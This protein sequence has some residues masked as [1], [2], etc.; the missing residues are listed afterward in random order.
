MDDQKK[1]MK[2]RNECLCDAWKVI[3]L[4]PVTR[5]NKKS[6]TYWKWIKEQFDERKNFGTYATMHMERDKSTMSHIWGNIQAVC[7][8][9]HGNRTTVVNRR[10]SATTIETQVRLKLARNRNILTYTLY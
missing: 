7:N 1:R 6:D 5:V 8:K 10:E 2:W 9:F 3:S 4:D